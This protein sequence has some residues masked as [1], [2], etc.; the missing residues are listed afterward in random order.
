MEI[1]QKKGEIRAFPLLPG[2]MWF[3]PADRDQKTNSD[4][5]NVLNDNF[6]SIIDNWIFSESKQ[7]HKTPKKWAETKNRYYKPCNWMKCSKEPE[8]LVGLLPHRL[9]GVNR[10]ERRLL[11]L[12][13]Y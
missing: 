11:L 10:G 5:S 4:R 3:V 9:E 6:D 8:R 12:E 1:Q 13:K 7:V 2:E